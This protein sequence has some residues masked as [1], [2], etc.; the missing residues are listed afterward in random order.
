MRQCYNQCVS[1]SVRQMFAGIAKRY[2]VANNA[3]SF[4]M[5][6]GWKRLL[7]THESIRPGA[8]VLDC[9]TGT[10][11][12]AF[13]ALSRVMPRGNVVGIDF[14][15]EMIALARAKVGRLSD[16]WLQLPGEAELAGESIYFE[17][18]NMLALPY[19]EDSFDA[20]TVAFG[21]RNT[22]DPAG[23]VAEMARVVKP[24]GAVLILE[25]GTPPNRLWR[26]LYSVYQSSAL[27]I[28]GGVLSGDVAAYKYLAGTT[29]RFPSGTRFVELMDSAT[30]FSSIEAVPLLGGV[31]YIYRGIVA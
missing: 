28:I 16:S 3:I 6:R 4:G 10:G 22:D 30:S 12:V 18:G 25:T 15:P 11:D 19:P 14:T 17:V 24:G 13:L 31:T 8:R 20:A 5:H 27:W 1:D 9:A 29:R 23:A 2:D 21:V 26:A 7:V